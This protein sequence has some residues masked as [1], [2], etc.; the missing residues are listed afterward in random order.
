MD[1]EKKYNEA[2]KWM[3]E[4]YPGLHGATKEDAEHYFPEL[5]ESEDERIRKWLV[6]YF[7]SIKKT[8]WV[9][10]DIT[11]E[12]IL[13]WLEKQKEPDCTAEIKEWKKDFDRIRKEHY[14]Q[15]PSCWDSPIMTHEMIMEKQKEQKPEL[16]YD[17]ELD[18]AAMEFYL[19]GGAK[20]PVD[21][22]G[23][24]PMVKMAEFGATWMK[25]RMEKEK[26][27]VNNPKWTELTWEDINYLEDLMSKV[28]YEFRNG[29][30]AESFG[31]EV[32]KK[33]REYK[34]DDS[35]DGRKPAE[36]SEELDVDT[37]REWSM[38]YAPDIRQAIEST[39]YHFYNLRPHW[40]PNE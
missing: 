32:L 2:L 5:R 13:G 12:Q 1:Y 22:T 35:M 15:K 26:K 7:S 18:N 28:H 16:Y 29:I 30:G 17:K 11:C 31:K 6:D 10:R 20:S 24:V 8:V 19:S 23:L 25:E 21:S 14:G 9:H 38:R 33:F 39:A 27:P 37:L 3:R 40:K 4:L 34:D 36:W